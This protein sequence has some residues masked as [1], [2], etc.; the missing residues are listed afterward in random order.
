MTGETKPSSRQALKDSLVELAKEEKR[1]RFLKIDPNNQEANKSREK[2]LNQIEERRRVAQYELRERQR[3]Y[4]QSVIAQKARQAA[5][6]GLDDA[7]IVDTEHE[8]LKEEIWQRYGKPPR[9]ISPEDWQRYD[10]SRA[11]RD[12]ARQKADQL[13]AAAHEAKRISDELA[14]TFEEKREKIKK[15]KSSKGISDPCLPC[16]IGRSIEELKKETEKKAIADAIAK[17]KESDFGK[18]EEGKKVVKKIEELEKAGKIVFEKF[19]KPGTRGAWGGGKVKVAARYADDVDSIASEL[20]HEATHAVYEDENP[21]SNDNS[22]KEEMRTNT[23]Q[24]NLYEEQRLDGFEDE[25]L[26]KRRNARRA[27]KLEDNIKKRYKF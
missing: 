13:Q 22:L 4:D 15:F 11:T 24:L 10:E 14:R 1:L 9:N 18:T 26:E 27:G 20:V 12:A 5:A 19:E 17:I 21:E 23:N 16:P 2:I 3:I 25:G 6:E 8:L 7:D